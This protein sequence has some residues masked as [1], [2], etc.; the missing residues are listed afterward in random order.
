MG[1]VAGFLEIGETLE[2]CAMREVY[3]ETSLRIHNLQYYA[4]QPWPFPSNLMVGFTADY[5]SGELQIDTEELVHAAFYP[6]ESLTDLLLPL[7]GS[8]AYQMLK[9][10]VEEV[11][12]A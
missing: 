11:L 5:L 4:S 7:P 9:S 6:P 1:T 8:L 12:G 2:E 3:E 10:R